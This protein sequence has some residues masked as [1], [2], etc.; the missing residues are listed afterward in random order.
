MRCIL[1]FILVEIRFYLVKMSKVIDQSEFNSNEVATFIID[2][3]A[4]LKFSV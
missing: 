4:K 2:K 1:L 3:L